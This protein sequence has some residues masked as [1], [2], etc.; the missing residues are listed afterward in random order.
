MDQGARVSYFT[1]SKF[2]GK[3]L[4]AVIQ[5]EAGF[6]VMDIN[7]D[8][9][10]LCVFF[11]FVDEDEHVSQL[12]FLEKNI[13]VLS[14]KMRLYKDN[15]TFNANHGRTTHGS[16]ADKSSGNL[17]TMVVLTPIC[18]QT[19]TSN[20][21]TFKIIGDLFTIPP[22]DEQYHICSIIGVSEGNYLTLETTNGE[23][24]LYEYNGTNEH[25]DKLERIPGTKEELSNI[26]HTKYGGCLWF[27]RFRELDVLFDEHRE[28]CSYCY[29]TEKTQ[30]FTFDSNEICEICQFGCIILIVCANGS[31]WIKRNLKNNTSL[32]ALDF[33]V[34]HAVINYL[35]IYAVT[36]D[37][38]VFRLS[39]IIDQD[40]EKVFEIKQLQGCRL[41]YAGNFFCKFVSREGRVAV[42][43][44]IGSFKRYSSS[45]K[46]YRFEP[47]WI[48]DLTEIIRTTSIKKAVHE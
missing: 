20:D 3:N 9:F 27:S 18:L 39:C 15:E 6:W 29:I 21:P 38:K 46:D 1:R 45:K 37:E 32:I 28:L 30:K 7:E 42:I 26:T 10:V 40:A 43:G 36:Y 12:A 47:V 44:N 5:N 19:R 8:R 35:G 31:L 13:I 48:D 14:N 34:K 16:I 33:K 17:E 22:K 24:I 41:T 23:K 2:Y 25:P 4:G 11:G